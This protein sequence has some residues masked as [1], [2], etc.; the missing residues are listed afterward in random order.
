MYLVAFVLPFV[1]FLDLFAEIV[2]FVLFLVDFA[3]LR[4]FH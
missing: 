2:P 1:V 3:I 4:L